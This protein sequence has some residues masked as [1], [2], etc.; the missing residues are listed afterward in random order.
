MQIKAQIQKNWLKS[1]F[2]QITSF[3]PLESNVMLTQKMKIFENKEDY[4]HFFCQNK[5]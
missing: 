5:G 1:F 2:P 4:E 3:L